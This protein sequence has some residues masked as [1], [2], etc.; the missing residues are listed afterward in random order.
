MP[1]RVH[2]GHR[3]DIGMTDGRNRGTGMRQVRRVGL[4]QRITD[5]LRNRLARA[6][7]PQSSTQQRSSA[8]EAFAVSNVTVAV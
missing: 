1:L 7:E 8:T 6:V 3:A 2:T 5:V 4:H